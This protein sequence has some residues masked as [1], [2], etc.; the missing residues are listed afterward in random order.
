MKSRRKALLGGLSSIFCP[1]LVTALRS[2]AGSQRRAGT[3]ST[4]AMAVKANHCSRQSSHCP[5]TATAAAA[6]DWAE[7][8]QVAAAA[9]SA[10]GG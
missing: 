2:G 10:A 3:I 7:L 4:Q 8:L 1:L 9:W 5:I 6:Q